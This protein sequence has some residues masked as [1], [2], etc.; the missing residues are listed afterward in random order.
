MVFFAFLLLI[1]RLALEL[2]SVQNWLV[3]K[4]TQR[5]SSELDT[6]VEIDHVSFSLFDKVYLDDLLIEDRSQD[7]LL[8]ART[9]E[10]TL[11]GGLWQMVNGNIQVEKLSLNTAR[12]NLYKDTVYPS[13]NME[14]ILDYFKKEEKDTSTTKKK[15]PILVSMTEMDLDDVAIDFRDRLKGDNMQGRIGMGRFT[16]FGF[17]S[18]SNH[19]HLNQLVLNDYHFYFKKEEKAPYEAPPEDDDEEEEEEEDDGDKK[20]FTAK[21][22][23]FSLSNGRFK[24][25]DDTKEWDRVQYETTMDFLHLDVEDIQ[26]RGKEF[27]FHEHLIFG[28]VL[29]HFSAKE[30][31]GFV[32]ESLSSEEVRVDN[33][34]AF[35]G[36]VKLK[37]PYSEIGDSIWLNYRKTGYPGFL[38]YVN[39][40][41]MK[42]LFKEGSKIALRDIFHFAPELES[43]KYFARNRE[44]VIE[45][46][47]K[48]QG[49][50]NRLKAL[51]FKLRLFEG[52]TVE[53]D[54]RSKNLTI[55][56]E[57]FF[58]LEITKLSTDIQTL[59]ALVPDFRPPEQFDKIGR[60]VFKGT[61]Y[62]FLSDFNAYG[63][64]STPLG[65]V[66]SD[67]RLN[68]VGGEKEAEFSGNLDL[69]EFDLAEWTDNPDFGK[70]TFKSKI[71]N[72]TGLKAANL[73][74]DL[75]AE[76][77]SLTFRNY[78]YKNLKVTGKFDQKRF[79]GDLD[80]SD[81]NIMMDF[82]GLVDFNDSIPQFDFVADVEKLNFKSLNLMKKD[83]SLSGELDFN[84]RG[85]TLDDL[86]GYAKVN[87]LD[88]L[89]EGESYDLGNAYVYAK[90]DSL[91]NRNVGVQSQVIEGFAQG[92]FQVDELPNLITDFLIRNHPLICDRIGL[93]PS[94]KRIPRNKYF[95]F[96]I[97]LKDSKN[98][99]HLLYSDL[100]TIVGAELNGYFNNITDSIYLD[101]EIKEIRVGDIK[102][103]GG[104]VEGDFVNELGRFD[105]G[106]PHFY[107]RDS[108]HIPNIGLYNTFEGDTM[109]FMLTMS[110]FSEMFDNLNLEGRVHPDED[111][112]KV[113]FKPS[114]MA[115]MNLKWD[116][117]EDNYIKFKK[118]YIETNHFVL[119]NEERKVSLNSYDGKGLRLNMNG[120]DVS[121]A[122]SYMPSELLHI[123]GLADFEV[124]ADDIFKQ[125]DLRAKVEMDSF[126]WNGDDY[127][128]FLLL[129]ETTAIKEKIEVSTLIK[130]GDKQLD[131]GGYYIPWNS[132]RR[133]NY[134]DADLSIN[135]YPVTIGEYFIGE[136]ISGT[137]GS[138]NA[139][140]NAKGF[141]DDPRLD[142]EVR[143]KDVFT[144]VDYL[145][146]RLSVPDG[147]VV[148]RKDEFDFSG[149]EVYDKEYNKAV[150]E[151]GI[152]HDKFK[153]FY[154]NIGIESEEFI[155]LD[156]DREDNDLFYGMG[157]G[158]VDVHFESDFK[159]TQIDVD[160]TTLKDTRIF[161]PISYGRT[162]SE[163]SFI[164]F[165]DDKKE[166]SLSINGVSPGEIKGVDFNMDLTITP[167]AEVQ[168][169]IDEQAGDILKGRGS[170]DIEINVTKEGDFEMYGNY[171]VESGSYLFTLMNVVNK[172]F[173]IKKGGSIS[174][175]G[176]PY[177]AQINLDATYAKLSTTPY[178]LILEYL[179]TD[180][181]RTQAQ[182]T[183]PIGLNMHLEGELFKPDIS[184]DIEF[185]QL[186]GR[187]KSYTDNKMRILREDKHELNR[188]VLGLI[189]FGSFLPSDAA[190][191]SAGLLDG[192]I[193]TLSELLSNQLS[194][195]VSEL[196][197]EVITDVEFDINY[198]YY[199]YIDDQASNP[200]DLNQSGSELEIRFSKRLFN[201]R[202]TI[203]AGSNFDVDG[204]DN[205]AFL[206]GDLLI[207]YLL[208]QDGRFKIRFYSGSDV[209]ITG[210]KNTTGVGLKYSRE[211]D[212]FRELFGRKVE[213]YDDYETFRQRMQ[214]TAVKSTQ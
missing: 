61:F 129:A 71:D 81:P 57:E 43:N 24:L 143:L 137:E 67:I 184:F 214:E 75:S 176:D 212:S 7:T 110:N 60:V 106:I 65:D 160:A 76:V 16:G 125:K 213:K 191:A 180:D 141:P 202:L 40:V 12:I 49:E 139:E 77:E 186:R 140:I 204:G 163:L 64:L 207:E 167:E 105:I 4:V 14:F 149:L 142:G 51:G 33:R 117:A 201:N 134:F 185:P 78:E 131:I 46:S 190:Y 5:L 79:E 146:A 165:N 29:D 194:I 120:F 96:D 21:V 135:N 27:T 173:N 154:L 126:F 172:P 84:F 74:A 87:K 42:A 91:G 98:F 175:T 30:K 53:G 17:D 130:R 124:S 170:G 133:P 145:Q 114:T 1:L 166:Q 196:L 116:I 171:Y 59:R 153:L 23:E 22:D 119:I 73:H 31:C 28:G 164:T 156:T 69:I 192:G 13:G 103:I 68:I 88:F 44:E 47:G 9:L 150:A 8:Y 112:F 209:D 37:T 109:D 179:N 174:W 20:Y 85:V 97:D 195:Y 205:G 107:F 136:M 19:V 6:R 25:D 93:K 18:D 104:I 39:D 82:D 197:S 34:E 10:A 178:N 210:R 193:N 41:R 86:D 70:V 3:D 128:Q 113:K 58:D 152:Y 35:L 94:G 101:V 208:T 62:G 66:R 127:G 118:D 36:N 89:Y 50:V 26:I 188:Q 168:L 144:T 102:L 123:G 159:T 15:K 177:G 11:K 52:T 122:N 211:F 203:N 181:D 48:I 54:F 100:D 189:A 95:N 148:V 155:A 38:D 56:G 108:T 182:N 138:F 169:I 45:I 206:A 90:Y 83:F 162:G 32:L 200:D 151:G 80:I 147:L 132:E 161:I 63:Y 121:I 72:A 157:R 198:R 55:K 99:G 187:I 2:E 158:K 111:M 199:E 115:I 183:T 92:N